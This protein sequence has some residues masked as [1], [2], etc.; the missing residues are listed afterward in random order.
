MPENGA[1]DVDYYLVEI[2]YYT[3]PNNAD[4]DGDG[5]S[6][7]DISKLIA[8]HKSKNTIATL[9]AIHP[10]ERFG[11][12]N[13]SDDF[14]TEFHEKHSG[15]SS[16]VNGG[17]FVFEPSILDYLQGGDPT[18]LERK[19]LENAAKEKQLAAFKHEGF[20]QCMDTKRDKDKLNN[21]IK[22]KKAPWIS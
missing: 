13:I 6:D 5:V 9:T 4:T 2:G 12:L 20:W 15:E 17:F 10:P 8:F 7:V 21:L 11:V 18:I 22:N 16:W 1:G 3:D 14:V 19:P